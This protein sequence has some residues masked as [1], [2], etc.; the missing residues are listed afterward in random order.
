MVAP[1]QSVVGWYPRYLAELTCGRRWLLR[2][3]LCW[4]GFR[5][6]DI[7]ST[8]LLVGWNS[9]FQL[10]SQMESLSR[11]YCSVS[12]SASETTTR[13]TMVSSANSRTVDLSFSWIYRSCS[14]GR[15]LVLTLTL[16]GR[17][18][19]HWL[20][21]TWILRWQQLGFGQRGM[22]GSIYL[23]YPEFRSDVVCAVEGYDRP[24]QKSLSKIHD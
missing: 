15:G 22:R 11:S 8:W 19:W 18:I 10:F 9:I 12:Q 6:R 4:I 21:Q 16:E 3:Y 14:K 23:F 17:P 7:V 5:F 13:Y 1:V 2:L 20:S 24:C